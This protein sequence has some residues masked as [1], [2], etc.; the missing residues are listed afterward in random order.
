MGK[1]ACRID[2]EAACTPRVAGQ[3]N[4]REHA[5]SVHDLDRCEA[6]ML[7]LQRTSMP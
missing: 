4:A 5:A 3:L 2:R 7:D 1:A 6:A